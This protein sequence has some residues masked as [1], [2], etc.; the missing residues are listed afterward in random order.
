MNYLH[1]AF[2]NRKMAPEDGK[3]N[4]HIRLSDAVR[5]IEDSRMEKMDIAM[6]SKAK[7]EIEMK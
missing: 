2:E 7:E 3:D 5:L 1:A 4:M 6:L